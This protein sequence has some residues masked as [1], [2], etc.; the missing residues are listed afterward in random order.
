MG[1]VRPET[2]PSPL[3]EGEVKRENQAREMALHQEWAIQPASPCS[4][5]KETMPEIRQDHYGSCSHHSVWR[6]I[7]DSRVKSLGSGGTS[8]VVQWL[9][10]PCSPGRGPGF[11]PWSKKQI[12][13][14]SGK[15]RHKQITLLI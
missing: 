14:A 12:L 7:A 4:L 1:G 8:L 10:T 13:Y 15:T 2:V 9:K 11:D 3:S 6:R 5:P